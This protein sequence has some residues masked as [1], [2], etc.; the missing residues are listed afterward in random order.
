MIEQEMKSQEVRDGSFTKD[1][2]TYLFA[3]API[4]LKFSFNEEDSL[5]GNQI[6]DLQVFFC[7]NEYSFTKVIMEK[8]MLEGQR[9]Y[10]VLFGFLVSLVVLITFG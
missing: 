4:R 1:G 8:D 3:K 9:F 2:Q 6:A 10:L 7:V 5:S